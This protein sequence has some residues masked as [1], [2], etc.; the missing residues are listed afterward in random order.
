M[1]S[2]PAILAAALAATA[3]A[4]PAFAE[5][6]RVNVRYADLD[7]STEAGQAQL[8]RRI[9]KAVRAACGANET[10]VGTRLPSREAQACVERTKPTVREQVAANIA[11][12]GTRG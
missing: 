7:L 12:S 4:T 10:N 6:D 11:R 8:E 9:D 3:F 5:S 2:T 1:R